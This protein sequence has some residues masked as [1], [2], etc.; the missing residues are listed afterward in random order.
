MRLGESKV[1]NELVEQ[2]KI[3]DSIV[4]ILRD[5]RTIGFFVPIEIGETLVKGFGLLPEGMSMHEKFLNL[6]TVSTVFDLTQI[7][8]N[9]RNEPNP[10]QLLSNGDTLGYFLPPAV[11]KKLTEAK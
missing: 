4:R 9:E 11:Y 3:A 8:R 1:E 2:F 5:G 10:C 7:M 6:E